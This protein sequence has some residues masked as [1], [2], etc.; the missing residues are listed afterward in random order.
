VS[1][2]C[3]YWEKELRQ[4]SL[5]LIRFE[6]VQFIS[7]AH[8]K[9]LEM[10]GLTLKSVFLLFVSA[11]TGEGN[12]FILNRL[13]LALKTGNITEVRLV[14]QSSLTRSSERIKKQ[15]FT[16]WEEA[17]FN[18]KRLAREERAAWAVATVPAC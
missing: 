14:C 7:F 18:G 6:N 5:N 13:L 9:C 2:Y 1:R 4:I 3:R 17:C 8:L 15:C 11:S 16:C 10:Q 12:Y